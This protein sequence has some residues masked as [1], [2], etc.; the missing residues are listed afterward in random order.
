M[1]GEWKKAF[2]AKNPAD[3]GKC[4]GEWKGTRKEKWEENL[5]D[6]WEDYTIA[7]ATE[8]GDVGDFEAVARAVV[9]FHGSRPPPEMKLKVTFRRFGGAGEW[10]IDTLLADK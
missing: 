9:T 10:K 8:M 7:V 1:L 4:F 2:E 3:V 5:R 6:D